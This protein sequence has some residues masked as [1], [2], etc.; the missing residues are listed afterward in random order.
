MRADSRSPIPEQKY[1]LRVSCVCSRSR[2]THSITMGRKVTLAVCTLNQWAMDFDG[3]YKRIL[4]S[5]KEAKAKGASFRS[6]PELEVTGYGCADHFYESD[7]LLHSWE[8]LASL[9]RDPTCE[10]IMVDVG[11]PVMHRNV[12]YNCRVIFL[13]KKILLI[14]PKLMM[15]DDGCYRESRWFTPWQ[16][17]HRVEEF[18]LPRMI[19]EITDQKVVPIGDALI[20]TKD[21]CIGFEI[22]EELWNPLSSHIMASLDGAEIINQV[23]YGEVWRHLH[24]FKPE[25]L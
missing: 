22:C 17:P 5:I 13:N 21:T 10:G 16:K 24:V 18:F 2:S 4:K 12:T 20:S 15:C 25:R 11:M 14:R 19:S 23:G 9:L 7:T 3:N 6:G 1:R 8:V